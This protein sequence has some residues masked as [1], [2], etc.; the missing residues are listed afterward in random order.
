[1]PFDPCFN[2]HRATDERFV[3]NCKMSNRSKKDHV[4]SDQAHPSWLG[5]RLANTPIRL[6]LVWLAALLLA[7]F[8]TILLHK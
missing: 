4:Q 7:A 8:F 3:D 6:W 5:L 2:N 1:M